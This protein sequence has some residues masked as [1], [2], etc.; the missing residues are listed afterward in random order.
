MPISEKDWPLEVGDHVTLDNSFLLSSPKE[1]CIIPRLRAGLGG[2]VR[3]VFKDRGEAII[4]FS[5]TEYLFTDVCRDVSI[6]RRFQNSKR[7]AEHDARRPK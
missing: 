5:G 7:R 2:I 4:E 6:F 3:E 1:H